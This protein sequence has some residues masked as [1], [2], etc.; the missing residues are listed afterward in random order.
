MELVHSDRLFYVCIFMEKKL[1]G[2]ALA[3]AWGVLPVCLRGQD[4]EMDLQEVEVSAPS[5]K[6]YSE[7][8]RVLTVL[9]REEIERLPVRTVDELLDQVAGLDVRQ[10]G[11]GGVQAD[12][13]IR[14]GTADQVLVL[15]N[16]VNVT[17]PQT[18]H[19][20]L[21]VPVNLADVERVEVLQGSAARV[22]GVNAFSGAVNIVT[23]QARRDYVQAGLTTGSYNTMGQEA[24]ASYGT[25][26]FRAFASASHQRS[27]GYMDTTD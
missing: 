23:G 18:G 15:L 24:S 8:G 5:G 9:D 13:S 20:N 6:M 3:M 2:L 1:L 7:L 22:L 10:R 17:N 4:R 27:D 26:G 12:L 14:G 16:G 19:Y 21:D 11:T 25:G